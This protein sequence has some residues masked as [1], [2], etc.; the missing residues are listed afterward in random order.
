MSNPQPRGKVLLAREQA[1]SAVLHAVLADTIAAFPVAMGAVGLP[2][3][4]RAFRNA[5]AAV[6]PRFEA[7]RL[8][9]GERC[10]IARHAVGVLEQHVVWQDQS[11]SRSLH[12]ALTESVAPLAL[13]RLAF[14]GEPGW[15]PSL[16]YRGERW[17][18]TR[19]EALGAQLV[20]RGLA[21]RDAGLAL[22][23]VG[24][25]VLD[26]GTLHLPGRKIA[27]LGG[28]AEMAPTRFWLEAGAD[29]LWLDVAPPPASWRELP[30]LAGRL[31]WPA[32]NVDLLTRPQEVLATLIA[33]ADGDPLDLG[34]YAYAPGQARELRLTSTMN[35]LVNALPSDLVRS[36]TMLVSPT[37]PTALSPL[38]L[39]DMRA[40]GQ[41]R[42]GW[43]TALARLGLLGRGGGNVAVGDAAVTRSVVGTQGASYQ[44]AQ[45]LGK[46]LVAE[47]WAAHGRTGS[48]GSTASMPLR[49][50]AN[51][52]AIT[53]TRSLAHPVFAAAFGGA[54]AF[55]VETLAPRQSRR[56]SGLLALGDWL[57]PELPVPGSVRVHG[58]IHT[59]PYPLEPT[60][61]VAAAIGFA[62]SPRLLR[63]LI[64]T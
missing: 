55:G 21:T 60:L 44:A 43:E 8:A 18:G 42:P 56:L 2:A 51:T 23:W 45:Y 20:D 33:F 34:L 61:R 39:G 25:Q 50:S 37:T 6:L 14:E 35:A 16:I 1:A 11:G 3:D 12:E 30:G 24:E 27:V 22:T 17:D 9:S 26:A 28:G 46:V 57:R 49:V 15:Q 53:R 5:Y 48:T 31:Y 47:G 38:D 58:G 10:D 13:E 52:A 7:T 40:R 64:G 54:A 32:G 63:G 36:V 19:L 41:A 29:V 4:P 62:R 59:L